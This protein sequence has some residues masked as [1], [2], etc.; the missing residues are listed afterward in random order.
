MDNNQYP[1]YNGIPGQPADAGMTQPVYPDQPQQGFTQQGYPSQQGQGFTQQGYPAQQ[2]QGFTQQGY[3]GQQG[4]GFTQQGYPAQQGQGFTQP[5]YPGQQGQ[6][7]TQQG[8]PGQQGQGFTQ[9]GYPGQQGQ[10]FNQTG[11]PSSNGYNMQGYGQPKPKK[12]VNKKLLIAIISTVALAAILAVVLILVLKPKTG[13]KTKEEAAE[14]FLKA[15]CSLDADTMIKYSLPK[16]IQDKAFKY[17][18]EEYSYYYSSNI[19]NLKEMYQRAYFGRYYDSSDKFEVRNIKVHD[20]DYYG[21]NDDLDEEIESFFSRH[22]NVDLDVQDA[23]E[24]RVDFEYYESGYYGNY[25]EDEYE[26]FYMY[27]VKNR[28]YV[29]PED[30][31]D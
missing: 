7:F 21:S 23:V 24:V 28:W 31:I 19:T 30:V 11:Y 8:Y 2:G 14:E 27:K 26:Y 3:P 6:G 9:Q 1:N 18:K 17:A 5:V 16:N 13:A 29:F 15:W 22:L 12:P 20:Y 10:G 4:Q 25:W